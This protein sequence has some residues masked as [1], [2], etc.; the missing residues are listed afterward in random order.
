MIHRLLEHQDN[1]KA[2]LA[3]EY[4]FGRKTN[5]NLI[6]DVCHF[7]ELGGGT[8]FTK[9]LETPVS[10]ANLDM[11]HVVIMLD[12]SEPLQMWF[13]LET[14][15]RNIQG[16]IKNS[17][18]S[19]KGRDL[20]L[21]E[22]LRKATEARID[23]EHP[24]FASMEPFKVQ[25]VII[26]G[27]YDV[28]HDFDPEAKKIICRTL[29]FFAHHYGASLQFY[30]AKDSG[31]VKKTRDLL[32]FH[33]FGTDPGKGMS[34][35]YNKPLIIPAFSDSFTSIMGGGEGGGDSGA[36]SLEVLKHHYTTH[37]PQSVT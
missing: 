35:D 4:T 18:E 31:S 1:A 6:K 17:V 11:L 27:K 5:Q 30:S 13:T 33:A 25:L 20:N 10:A 8:L 19:S 9:L 2:T 34:Q 37:F 7:W 26:G 21:E 12:L 28:Y 24:D 22:H 32:N 16:H 15:L 36:W 14:L 3:L 29:R 23:R